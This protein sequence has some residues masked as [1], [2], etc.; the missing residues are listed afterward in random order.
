LHFENPAFLGVK[1]FKQ[2]LIISIRKQSREEISTCL[3]G[4]LLHI[5]TAQNIQM[6]LLKAIN[7]YLGQNTFK[8]NL[9]S[10]QPS[11]R[12]GNFSRSVGYVNVKIKVV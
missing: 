8:L 5:S 2:Q 4:E 9:D 1:T 3:S 10:D 11:G 7:S 12:F 6:G